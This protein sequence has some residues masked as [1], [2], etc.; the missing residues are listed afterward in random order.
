MN[1]TGVDRSFQNGPDPR[2]LLLCLQLEGKVALD[3]KIAGASVQ[4]TLQM[5]DG[6]DN[7]VCKWSR[8]RP[9]SQAVYAATM[10]CK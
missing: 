4:G 6:W 3:L 7:P 8:E 5:A 1:S 10:Q 9:G 2:L